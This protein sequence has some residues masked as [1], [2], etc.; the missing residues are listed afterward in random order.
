MEDN[1][2]MERLIHENY[3]LKQEIKSLQE[4]IEQIEKDKNKSLEQ[5][6]DEGVDKW[7]EKFKHDVDI[8]KITTFEMFGQKMEI[9]ILPDI[10]EKAIYKK[11]LKIITAMAL[12]IKDK[13]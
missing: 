8:G 10:M 5:I 11:C 7:F 3:S 1:S 13:L 9:D 2:N 12:E 6:I 4:M